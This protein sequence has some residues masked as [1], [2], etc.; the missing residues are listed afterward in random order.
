MKKLIIFL[1]LLI[2][3]KVLAQNTVESGSVLQTSV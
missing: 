1:F 2:G 3:A